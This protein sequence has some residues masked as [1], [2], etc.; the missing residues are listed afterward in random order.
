MVKN[1]VY[2]IYQEALGFLNASYYLK[3]KIYSNDVNLLSCSPAYTV[4]QVFA[5][6]LLLKSLCKINEVGYSKNHK[7]EYLFSCLPAR[8]IS[9]IEKEYE[10]SCK[11]KFE[12]SYSKI[13]LR[14][15][16]DCLK[17]YDNA[18]VEWRYYYEKSEKAEKNL[19]LPW[20][21]LEIL[22]DILKRKVENYLN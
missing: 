15:L 16:N 8:V 18:F 11:E 20:I 4:N 14:E 7:L 5:C 12:S 22:I 13:K 1:V 21:D 3:N 17:S 19:C 10:L 9:E 6:E 2:I